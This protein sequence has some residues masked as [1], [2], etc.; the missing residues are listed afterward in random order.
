[1]HI[2]K[3][4]EKDIQACLEIVKKLLEHFTE[5]AVSNIAKDLTHQ[6]FLIATVSDKTV[7]FISFF[8][9]SPQVA[10]ITWLAVEPEHQ[11]HGIGTAMVEFGINQLKANDIQILE[12][13]TLAPDPQA[14][15]YNHTRKFY[16]QLGFI[17]LETIDPFQGWDLGNPCAVYVKVL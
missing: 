9:K 8:Q 11:R 16:E 2:K 12:V 10:E 1:M 3:G 5:K 17:H 15:Q 4:L 7:G 6:E 13:K 14:P